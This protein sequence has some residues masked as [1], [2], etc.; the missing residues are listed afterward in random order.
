MA[1]IATI[2]SVMPGP[3]DEIPKPTDEISDPEDLLR[4]IIQKSSG[5]VLKHNSETLGRIASEL[6]PETSMRASRSFRQFVGNLPGGD[7]LNS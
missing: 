2:R 3:V 1:D 5:G 6:D 7:F 4:Q